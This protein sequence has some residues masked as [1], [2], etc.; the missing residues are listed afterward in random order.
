ML[1]SIK[2]Q[3]KDFNLLYLTDGEQLINSIKCY[4]INPTTKIA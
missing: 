3:P 2:P 4:Y 1:Y